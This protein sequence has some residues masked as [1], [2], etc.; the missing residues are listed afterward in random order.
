MKIKK[1][2]IRRIYS[3]YYIFHTIAANSR[4]IAESTPYSG[5]YECLRAA[6]AYANAFKEV[7]VIVDKSK[8]K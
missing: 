2:V 7:P 6:K 5:H 3:E 1:I 4:L 8:A